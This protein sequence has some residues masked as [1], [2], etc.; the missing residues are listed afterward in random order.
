MTPAAAPSQRRQQ[1]SRRPR[2]P[3]RAQARIGYL[4]ASGYGLL[5][6]AFGVGPMVYAMY[7]AFT[8]AGDF[9]GLANFQK[10]FGD[11]RF[12]PAV[13]HVA[14]FLAVWLVSLL[15]LVV[16]LAL[17]VHACARVAVVIRALP[18]LHPGALAGSASVMLWLFLLD[19]SVSPV[20]VVLTQLGFENF[21]QTVALDNLPVIFTVIAFWAG[22]G[23]WIIIMYG[24]LNTIS[25]DVMEAARSTARE[26]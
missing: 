11:F 18:V 2:G 3:D 22:A 9:V 4:F 15:V 21:I 6:L 20:S 13:Q 26:P 7:L 14:A 25:I 19:P 8:K 17:I 1:A 10:V 12:V 5:L 24:A 16:L 23:G